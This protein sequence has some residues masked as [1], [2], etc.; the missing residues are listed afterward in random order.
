MIHPVKTL[1]AGLHGPLRTGVH[2]QVAKL[3]ISIIAKAV[4]LSSAAIEGIENIN[5][6]FGNMRRGLGKISA[7]FKSKLVDGRLRQN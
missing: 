4:V 5:G 2:Q 6:S 7:V 3:R 1:E